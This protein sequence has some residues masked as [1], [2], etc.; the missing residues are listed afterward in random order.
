MPSRLQDLFQNRTVLF[1]GAMGT[2]LYSRGIFINRCYD[3]L[4]LS[5]PE[6]VRSIHDEYL[7]AGA[8]IIETN[9]FGAN[10][11]RLARYGLQDQVTAINQAGVRIARQAVHQL[12]DK[13]AGTAWVAGSVGPLGV[14]LEPLGK[15]S[16]EEARL[17]FAEQVRALA[18]GGPGIGAD[19]IVIETM[20]AL[21]EAEQAILAAR[22]AA[23]HLPVMALVTVDE[24]AHCLD[25]ATAEAAASKLSMWGADAI[26]VNCS[27]G[28]ATVLTAIE[29]MAAESDLPLVV[30]P[31]AG[32]PR[33]VDGRNIYLCS[34]EYMASFARKF[35]KAGVQF[36]GGCCGTTPNHTRAMKSAMRAVDAQKSSHA[37]PSRAP[38]VTETP[39]PPLADRS[40]VGRLIH[41]G[42]F[43]TMVEIVPPKG[44]DCSKELAGASLLADLGVDVINVP[45]SPRASARMSAQ[46]LCIQIQQKVGIETILHY[47]C[48]DRNV[49]SIQSDL[50]GAASIGLKNILCLTGDPP[51]LGNYP[52]ATAVFDVD[53]I[54]LVNIVRR[55]NHGLDIGGN[56]IGASTGFTIACAANPG[57]PDIE[58][59]VRRFAYKVEAGAEYAITQ[60]VFDLSVLEAFLRRIEEFRI[61]V[62]AGIWPLTSLRNAEFMKNDLRVSVPDSVM[63]RM[64]AAPTPEAAR[65]E[66]ILI[67]QEMLEA[68]RPM[69]QGVQVSAPFGR[70][71]SA[72]EVLARVLPGAR[73]PEEGASVGQL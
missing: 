27:T 18:A 57:V 71:A 6:L 22:E 20:P 9:T 56:P 64:Q 69:V 59:E 19:L 60:P 66:G 36:I 26:G 62:I 33:A 68:A 61:P 50:L 17:A 54:G 46:S 58:N 42:K 30:M 70:Y 11:F 14:H 29:C 67:A 63:L 34:P 4:N 53:A 47:T 5:Q 1:D 40:R 52:D 73:Q 35:L 65:A 28:P 21:N 12:K 31:N 48:R 16:L 38:I 3:E 10:R 41:E 55:L 25:G 44:I 24:E 43:V 8:E 72:A 51:K 15:T 49:L 32:M 2:M 39:P 7:Q 23:P 45:D 37:H 13:Q